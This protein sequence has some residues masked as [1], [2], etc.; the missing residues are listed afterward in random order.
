[1]VRVW[2]PFIPGKANA[3]L[4]GHRSTICALVVI[5]A[6]NRIYSLSKDRCI[7]V[8]DVSALSCI[9]TYNK[10]PSELSEYT[11]MTIVFNTLTRT[12][13]IASMLIAVVVC[14]HV[15]NE[16]ASDGYTH[17]KGVSCVLYNQLFR[18]VDFLI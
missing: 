9:Q 11:P 7:K 16:E 10:L 4:S 13:I 12:M 18:V 8:W 17:T 2:N 5:D 15:I 1:M 3:V 6:G 14:E